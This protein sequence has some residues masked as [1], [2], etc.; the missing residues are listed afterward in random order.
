MGLATVIKDFVLICEAL[1]DIDGDCESV[2]SDLLPDVTRGLSQCQ[3][4]V[5]RNID[6]VHLPISRPSEVLRVT[7]RVPGKL[8]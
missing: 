7:L 1:E 2:S 6:N 4:S 8:N 5:T 3:H